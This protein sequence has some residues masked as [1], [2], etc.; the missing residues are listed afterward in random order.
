MHMCIQQYYI[1]ESIS[2]SVVSIYLRHHGLQPARLLC[3]CDSPGKNNG[4]GYHSLLQEVF[5]T[6][7][8]NPGLQHCRQILYHLSHQGSPGGFMVKNLPAD[9]GNAGDMSFLCQEGPLE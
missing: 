1:Y 4:V 3:L 7:G 2:R 6:Q 9:A 8:S 5:P